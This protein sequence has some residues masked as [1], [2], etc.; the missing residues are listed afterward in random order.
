MH[1]DFETVRF[2]NLMDNFP[3]G[4]TT[5]SLITK[6]D[7]SL[8]LIRYYIYFI[9]NK[10]VVAPHGN[11]SVCFYKLFL[12][13]NKELTRVGFEPTTSGLMAGALPTELSSPI[14]AVC[15]NLFQDPVISVGCGHTF[16]RLCSTDEDSLVLLEV[17][18]VDNKQLKNTSVFENRFVVGFVHTPFSCQ[19]FWCGSLHMPCTQ[20][21]IILWLLLFFSET[22]HP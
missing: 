20:R 11:F 12:G 19:L 16:C 21:V 10:K 6:R 7:I 18:P 2:C 13:L 4:A 1:L 8:R 5:F 14:L 15:K 9:S 22:I 3:Y 17:C